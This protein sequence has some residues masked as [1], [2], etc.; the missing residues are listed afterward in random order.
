MNEQVEKPLKILTI[1]ESSVGKTC[2][3]LR[4]T[5][6]NISSLPTL[7][8]DFSNKYIN[9]D[10]NNIKLGDSNYNNFFL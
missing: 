2:L 10:G 7:G 3:I 4:Y 6:C 1:G 5:N 9:I 8:V